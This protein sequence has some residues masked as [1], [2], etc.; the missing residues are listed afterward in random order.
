MGCLETAADNLKCVY[1]STQSFEI[2]NK[3]WE[4]QFAQPGKGS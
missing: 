1:T 4:Q 2:I 3:L